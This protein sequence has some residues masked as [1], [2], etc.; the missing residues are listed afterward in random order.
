MEITPV[1]STSSLQEMEKMSLEPCHLQ[2]YL[3]Q[4]EHNRDA[5]ETDVSE[6]SCL[7]NNM[8]S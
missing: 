3:C 1:L 5:N 8:V 6:V 2:D 7:D 4:E